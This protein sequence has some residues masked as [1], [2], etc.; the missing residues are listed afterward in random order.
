MFNKEKFYTNIYRWMWHTEVYYQNIY[1]DYMNLY[2]RTKFH[3]IYDYVML[4]EKELKFRHFQEFC[5]ELTKLLEIGD[6]M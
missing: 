3:S 6:K 5:K 4:C 2:N 1:I